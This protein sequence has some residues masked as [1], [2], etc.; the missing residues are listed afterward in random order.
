MGVVEN[1]YY[2]SNLQ[3]TAFKQIT[4]FHCLILPLISP[5]KVSDQYDSFYMSD[6]QHQ[7]LVSLVCL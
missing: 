1:E 3:H 5:I 4:T 6:E 7:A 2:L